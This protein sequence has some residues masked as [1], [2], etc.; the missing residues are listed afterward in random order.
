MIAGATGVAVRSVGAVRAGWNAGVSARA[1]VSAGGVEGAVLSGGATP[2]AENAVI[3][4]AAVSAGGVEGA[5]LSGDATPAAKA[6]SAE[7]G[8]GP[9][10]ALAAGAAVLAAGCAT[11]S[12][13]RC[14]MAGFTAISES[15]LSEGSRSEGA[16]TG[17]AE[18]GAIFGAAAE[19][20]GIAASLVSAGCLAA[21]IAGGS[22][23]PPAG[24]G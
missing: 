11:S 21:E 24:A 9:R 6:I 2:A 23:A 20:T 1:A 16:A 10:A 18:R 15:S 5:V 8:D 3:A 13:A 17:A 14:E 12:G 22:F 4:G 7:A 19:T